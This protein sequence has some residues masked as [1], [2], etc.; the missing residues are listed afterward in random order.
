MPRKTPREEL[1]FVPHRFGRS[2]GESGDGDDLDEFSPP[3]K[4]SKTIATS[5]DS[6]DEAYYDSDSE[7]TLSPYGPSSNSLYRLLGA[8][9]NVLNEEREMA[10][11]LNQM[12]AVRAM[13]DSLDETRK[14]T[15]THLEHT[16]MDQLE[17]LHHLITPAH[18]ASV[19]EKEQVQTASKEAGE[20][21]NTVSVP[22][23]LVSSIPSSDL[24]S[25][26]Q[27]VHTVHN[28][29]SETGT[30]TMTVEE[31]K[32]AQLLQ[33]SILAASICSVNCETS[34]TNMPCTA[35]DDCTTRCFS[36]CKSLE[37]AR[38]CT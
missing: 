30:A 37:S 5:V 28:N 18:I 31:A 3:A 17:H 16:L 38:S 27:T 25:T 15:L 32:E 13:I 10:M 9:E 24:G 23:A 34:C 29:T 21:Q 19:I 26:A 1:H 7:T 14:T 20:A 8:V 35:L 33:T 36:A 4:K 11:T 22:S 2:S 6:G 12:Q